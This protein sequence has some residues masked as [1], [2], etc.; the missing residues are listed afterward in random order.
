[1]VSVHQEA[2]RLCCNVDQRGSCDT[3]RC[4]DGGVH[5]FVHP[6]GDGFSKYGEDSE[7]EV[8]ANIDRTAFYFVHA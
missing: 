8:I 6:D 7:E 5:V 2:E 1:M 3:S 4:D